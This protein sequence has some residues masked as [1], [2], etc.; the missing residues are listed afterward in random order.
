MKLMKKTLIPLLLVLLIALVLPDASSCAAV[1][2]LEEIAD[3]ILWQ[4]PNW[5]TDGID[6]GVE[7]GGAVAGI[8]DVDNDTYEDIIIGA[9]K[10]LVAGERS[11]SAFIYLGGGGGVKDV[12][13]RQLIPPNGIS[14]SLFGAAVAAAGDVNGDGYDDVIVGA[15]YHHEVNGHEG[16]VYVY[17]GGLGGLTQT[18]AWSKI[19]PGNDIQFGYA[20]S[21]AGDVNHD[22]FDDILVGAP[23]YGSNSSSE[24]A[25]YLFLGSETGLSTEPAWIYEGGQAGATLGWIV[26]GIGNI[27]PDVDDYDDIAISAPGYDDEDSDEGLVMV[28]LGTATGLQAV[29]V[30]SVPGVEMGERFGSAVDGAGDVDG[31]GYLD[32]IVGARGYDGDQTD[33]GAAYLFSNSAAGLSTTASWMVSSDQDFS[34]FGISVAGLGD[35]NQDGYGDVAV[36]AYRYTDDQREEG[37]VFAYR[38]SPI[39]LESSPNWMAGGDKADAWFG[40]SISSAGDVNYDGKNDLIVGAPTYKFDE[41][42]V[43]GRAFVF[44]GAAA[45]EVTIFQVFLPAIIQAV[46]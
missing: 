45:G 21:S 33:I 20:V 10:Y 26:T 18:P 11:G 27:N 42:T 34:G 25:V 32:L 5:Y 30:W 2:A 6:S 23:F 14:G 19:G 43:M 17:H 8:G 7:Y 36:G 12:V 39:G 38:G 31:N 29:P 44:H 1:A 41:H 16:A 22:G 28:F 37:C 40:N 3:S 13:Q 46:P 9:P 24:G 15:P 35:V 4:V